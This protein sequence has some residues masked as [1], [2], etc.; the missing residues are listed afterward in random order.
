[1]S[2]RP[3]RRWRRPLALSAVAAVCAT[4]AVVVP[5]AS[6]AG[7]VTG[8]V[9]GTVFRDFDSDG[10][11]DTTGTTV[12]RGFAGVTARA[13]DADGDLVGTATSTADGTYQI[14]VAGAASTDLRVELELSAAQLAEGYTSSFASLASTW[15][16][17]D[18][19]FVTLPSAGGTA[20]G[21]D[22]AVHHPDDHV[23][24]GVPQVVIAQHSANDPLATSPAGARKSLVVVDW[25]VAAN[26]ANPADTSAQRVVGS[27]ADTPEHDVATGTLWGVT[28]DRQREHV[29]ST[30][31]A[32]RHGGLGRA[33]LGG[34]YRTDPEAGTTEVFA[35]LEELGVDTGRSLLNY[36]YGLPAGATT[37]QLNTARGLV[38]DDTMIAS[39]DAAMFRFAGTVGL[40]GTAIAP[41][42]SYLYVVNLYE[43][44]IVAVAIPDDG[45]APTAADVTEIPLPGLAPD[46]QPF[47]LTVHRGEI[48]V[49]IT[50]T[51]LGEPN[52]LA[53]RAELGFRVDSAPLAGDAVGPWR[54]VLNVGDLTFDRGIQTI[55]F[56]TGQPGRQWN[57]WNNTWSPGQYAASGNFYAYPQP[58]VSALEH[59]TE[60]NLVIGVLD[61]F[62]LQGGSNNLTPNPADP[63]LVIVY[64]SGDTYLA[65]RNADGT[66]AFEDAGEI[67]SSG[68]PA[69]TGQ[70]ATG[71]GPGGKEFFQDSNVQ[72]SGAIGQHRE[73]TMGGLAVLLGAAPSAA[74]A[75][76]NVLV[77]QYTPFAE[78]PVHY[79]SNG[80]RWL[81][82]GDGSSGKGYVVR[83]A[84]EPALG[85]GASTAAF[86]KAGGLGDVALLLDAAPV[87]IGNRVW[88]DA[89]R[90]GIQD[91]GEPALEGVLVELLDEHGDP[92]LR[93][94]VPVT[95]RT[96]SRGLYYFEV[97][98][99]TSYVV[100]FTADAG[101]DVSGLVS[102]GVT[103][104]AELL[105]TQPGSG[106]DAAVDSDADTTT[107][108][109]PVTVGGPGR[110]DHTLDAGFAV[111]P[112]LPALDKKVLLDGEDPTAPPA[113]SDTLYA[114]TTPQPR[115]VANGDT[116]RYLVTVSAGID[117]VEDV[118]VRDQL[119]SGVTYVSSTASQGAYDPATG[120]WTVG[121]LLAGATQT[122][123][124]TVTVDDAVRPG[125][126]VVN[127]AELFVDSVSVEDRETHQP[128]G[129][130]EG[131]RNTDSDPDSDGDGW[132]AVDIEVVPAVPG[133]DKKVEGLDT[134]TEPMP[135]SRGAELD[136]L[137]TVAAADDG[138]SLDASVRDLL[139]TGATYVSHVASRG[140]Y[141]AVAGVW[142]I[143]D[144][145]PSE[146]VTLTVTVRVADDAP[147]ETVITNRASLFV[148]TDPVPDVPG[149]PGKPG[150]NTDPSDGVD[151][152]D[153][154]VPGDEDS[155]TPVDGEDPDD[156]TDEPDDGSDEPDDGS[157]EPGDEDGSEDPDEL[158]TTGVNPVLPISVALLLILTGGGLLWVRREADDA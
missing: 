157:D 62:G 91:A 153:V 111:P 52:T 115:R 53:G 147:Q 46:E 36:E 49:G 67:A 122:L 54:E 87:Q 45:S 135:T 86:G 113:A 60:G 117:D 42:G 119:P 26:D 70:G 110:N 34:I 20:S 30:A 41:D 79:N 47:A 126:L 7:P 120:T 77:T 40:G 141:D 24:A 51:A 72:A 57:V 89:D 114:G 116:V 134:L 50:S 131:G 130:G 63:G 14:T 9:T 3:A 156:E 154:V 104:P 151:E 38:G 85:G 128:G 138:W 100:R 90:D 102:Y 143:G 149:S 83:A 150:K 18:V 152:V 61:R 17:S 74:A 155:D 121:D 73:A 39:R 107:R 25:D 105:L 97:E 80:L 48:F 118:E 139:P 129:P 132:D 44:S 23:P 65:G 136:Y 98:P 125:T 140:T 32:R 5:T 109:T 96:D 31:M 11:F 137:V 145:A 43:R 103:D 10:L 158:G 95:A 12:D 124:V 94:G 1:M 92:V 68:S 81:K 64:S 8:A 76:P 88:F 28:Y 71:E 56:L 75:S 33:G 112:T 66:Y 15:G 2:S 13:F 58:L 84:S 16:G 106:S 59:D 108:T 29:Y 69:R 144:L 21:A 55:G 123:V 22:F 127:A 142:Q 19:Q 146:R 6:A 133:L 101:T 82:E 93:G 27:F 78:P 99:G 37:A 35:D 148:G 4:G